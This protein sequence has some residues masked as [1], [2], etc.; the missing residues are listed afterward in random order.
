MAAISN[1]HFIVRS[2]S[3]YGQ[4]GGGFEYQDTQLGRW[5]NV[6][7]ITTCRC[8][9]PNS[10][11]SRRGRLS[12]QPKL[13]IAHLLIGRCAETPFWAFAALLEGATPDAVEEWEAELIPWSMRLGY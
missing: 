3:I 4:C 6:C 11:P 9:V 5:N 2:L 12:C 1:R 7:A 8:A 13:G 10:V